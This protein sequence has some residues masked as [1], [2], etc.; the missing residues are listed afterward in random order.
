VFGL[1][2]AI[3]VFGGVAHSVQPSSETEVFRWDAKVVR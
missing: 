1:G 2:Y 3:P